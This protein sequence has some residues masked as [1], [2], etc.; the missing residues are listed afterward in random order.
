MKR[1]RP[2]LGL[3][4]ATLLASGALTGC[5]VA[6]TGFSPGVAAEVGDTSITT[7]R[8]DEVA[9][10]YC[11]AL[12][13][14][15]EGQ[16]VPQRYLNGSVAGQLALAAAAEQLAAEHGVEP[17]EQHAA[18]VTQLRRAVA[19]L[20]EDQQDAV[21]EVES[22]GSLV[23]DLVI[24]V[25]RALAADEGLAD[26]T[27]E[28]VAELGNQ[29]LV[30]WIGEHDVDVNPRY[31]VDLSDGQPVRTDSETSVAV[32][33]LAA[34]ATAESPDQEYAATLPESQRCG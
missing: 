20:P 9:A 33:D 18:Q 34:A 27:D 25:G 26:P 4:A 11:D 28:Q 5:G 8:V 19:E 7:D 2:L 17:G 14:Q 22:A 15:L 30:D 31:G 12:R 32:S 10:S 6:G 29:A 23:S 21:L 13:P 24:G 1:T 3:A 16:V